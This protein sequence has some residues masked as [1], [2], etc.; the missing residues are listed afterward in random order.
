MNISE[1]LSDNRSGSLTITIN[2]LETIKKYVKE[3]LD[4]NSEQNFE[5]IHQASKKLIKNQPN[6]VLIRRYMNTLVNHYKKIQKN[7]EDNAEISGLIMS[8]IDELITEIKDNLNKVSLNGAKIITNFNKIMTISNSTVV[9]RVLEKAFEQKKKYEI[10]CLAS[11]PPGEGM[12]F[13][14]YL[15]DKD[16]KTT[17]VADSQAGIVMD[18]MNMVIIGADRLYEKGFVNKAGSL[19]L[20]LMAKHFNVPVY[21]TVETTKILKETERTIKKVEG[22]TEEIYSGDDISIVNSYFE[23]VPFELVSK[24]ICEEGVYE[25]PEFQSWFLGE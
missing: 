5:E 24:V 4:S 2:A 23:P 20:C 21:L 13:A 14:K 8:K 16:I 6:M 7:N 12:D 25:R 18:E 1:I 3:N 11:T 19:A 9:K 10:F 17:I 22:P 15:A